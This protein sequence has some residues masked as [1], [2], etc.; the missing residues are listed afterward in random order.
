MIEYATEKVRDRVK[1]LIRDLKVVTG[2]EMCGYRKCGRAIHYHHTNPKDKG[3][4]SL[5]QATTRSKP[6]LINTV[7]DEGG[8]FLCANCHAEAHDADPTLTN[9]VWNR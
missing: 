4:F 8:I 3:Q 6:V 1:R 5:S 7:L 2:C 9:H